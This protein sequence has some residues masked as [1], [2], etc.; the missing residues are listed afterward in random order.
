MSSLYDP[1]EHEVSSGTQEPSSHLG[2]SGSQQ[3]HHPLAHSV[4]SELK[5]L[6]ALWCEI[7][8]ASEI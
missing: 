3:P 6:A 2:N 7:L 8:Y 5:L 1:E 4:V